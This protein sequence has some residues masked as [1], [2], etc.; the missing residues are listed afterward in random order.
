MRKMVD[1]IR[2][3]TTVQLKITNYKA[4]GTQFVN[5][6]MISPL[7]DSDGVYRYSVGC[8]VRDDATC[9]AS[10]VGAIRSWTISHIYIMVPHPSSLH[11]VQTWHT[12][13]RDNPA[14]RTDQLHDFEVLIV[15]PF[16]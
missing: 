1:A 16:H 7:L 6:L 8:M 9:R 11:H 4:D 2:S 12:R 14:S 10:K 5:L 13:A 15:S 3:A